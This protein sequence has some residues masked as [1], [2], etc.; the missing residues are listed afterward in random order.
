MRKSRCFD[1][2]KSRVYG[3]NKTGSV[4]SLGWQCDSICECRNS[5]TV[6]VVVPFVEAVAVPYYP[7]AG[8]VIS[9]MGFIYTHPRTMSP[10]ITIAVNH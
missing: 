4:C 5:T 6:P 2:N 9:R 3:D 10:Y 8:L 7:V 1:C